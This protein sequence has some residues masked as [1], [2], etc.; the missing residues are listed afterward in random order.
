MHDKDAILKYGH[1][2]VSKF[3]AIKI[4]VIYHTIANVKLKY[5]AKGIGTMFMLQEHNLLYW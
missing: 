2:Y 1:I 5:N 4:L 3:V